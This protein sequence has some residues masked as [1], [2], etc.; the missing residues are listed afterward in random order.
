[1]S[2]HSALA[3]LLACFSSLALAQTSEAYLTD[4]APAAPSRWKVEGAIQAHSVA[5]NGSP[6]LGVAGAYNLVD[7]GSLG[8][9][10]FVPLAHTV[11]ESTYAIQFFGRARLA[12]AKYTDFFT[13]VD[14]AQNFFNFLPFTSY[15]LAVGSLT[16]LTPELSVGFLGGLEVA[17]VV[18]D[19]VGLERRNSLFVY[20]KVA[21]LADLAF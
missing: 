4:I 10:G 8:L 15:G 1:M 3:I 7:W 13:E 2:I 11:D 21:L 20:P 18:I 16:R 14:F 12:S 9:R 17:G 5:G 19:S 6:W